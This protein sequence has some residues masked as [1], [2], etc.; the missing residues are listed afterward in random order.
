MFYLGIYIG[1][2]LLKLLGFPLVKEIDWKWFVIIPLLYIFWKVI[3]K[4]FMWVFVL[5]SGSVLIYY[6]AKFM[7]TIL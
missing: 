2:V 4:T 1:L 3:V 6:I 7:L 5:V